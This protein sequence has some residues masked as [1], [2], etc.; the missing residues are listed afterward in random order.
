MQV[1]NE[2]EL[3]QVYDDLGK[4]YLLVEDTHCRVFAISRPDDRLRVA[5]IERLELAEASGLS[6]PIDIIEESY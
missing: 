5:D 4:Y 6:Y 3:E 1:S 2:T